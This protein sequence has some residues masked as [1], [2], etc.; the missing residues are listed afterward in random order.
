ML[1]TRLFFAFIRR[2]AAWNSRRRDWR[3]STRLKAARAGD[4]PRDREEFR[5]RLAGVRRVGLAMVV[6]MAMM[7]SYRHVYL[8]QLTTGVV[9]LGMLLLLVDPSQLIDALADLAQAFLQLAGLEQAA[10]ARP[11][12]SV[13][14][15]AV[16]RTVAATQAIARVRQARLAAHRIAASLRAA[17]GTLVPTS[18][19]RLAASLAAGSLRSNAA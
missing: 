5:R 6:V 18:H 10:M 7:L 14:A 11:R 15:A 13:S 1:S 9:V 4:L 8:D 17:L 3:Q 19:P 16:A 12:R 2:V